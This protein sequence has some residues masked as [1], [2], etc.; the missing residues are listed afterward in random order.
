MTQSLHQL[1]LDKLSAGDRLALAE[2]LWQSV[3]EQLD[4]TSISPEVQAEL[5]RRIALADADPLRGEAWETIRA[6]ARKR[7]GR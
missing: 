3:H 2:E 1:G 6:K 4:S 7:W 5:E